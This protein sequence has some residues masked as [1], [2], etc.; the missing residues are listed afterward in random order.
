M[1]DHRQRS[2]RKGGNAEIHPDELMASWVYDEKFLT[3]I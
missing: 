1:A 3:D 2:V